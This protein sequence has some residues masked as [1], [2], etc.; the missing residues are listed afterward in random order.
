[1]RGMRFKDEGD[2]KEETFDIR[3]GYSEH[4]FYHLSIFW[5]VYSVTM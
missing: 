2:L 1:M 5:F 4:C 3:K